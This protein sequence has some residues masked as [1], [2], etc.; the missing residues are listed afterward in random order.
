[1]FKSF[2]INR[3]L[4]TL[5]NN[6]KFYNLKANEITEEMV[7]EVIFKNIKKK[8]FVITP[9]SVLGL[10]GFPIKEHLEVL[11]NKAKTQQIKKILV[12]LEV[13]GILIKRAAKQ[14]FKGIRE[15]GYDW[16]KTD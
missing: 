11:N 8:N 9:L 5:C 10:T 13:K 12:A 7:I 2:K 14:D 16:I 4:D 3:L 6:L 15:I 1:M